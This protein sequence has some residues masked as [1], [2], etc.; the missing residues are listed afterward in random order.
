M[1]R[2]YIITGICRKILN[3]IS[4]E[5]DA[6][7]AYFCV[8]TA[9]DKPKYLYYNFG[10]IKIFKKEASIIPDERKRLCLYGDI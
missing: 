4:N 6:N 1:S 3:K 10:N 7:P 5:Q 8:F 2:M 9:V